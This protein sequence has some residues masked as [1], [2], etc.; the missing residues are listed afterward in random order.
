MKA[1]HVRRLLLH[2]SGRK[3]NCPC[4]QLHWYFFSMLSHLLYKG[5]ITNNTWPRCSGYSVVNQHKLFICYTNKRDCT[6]FCGIVHWYCW[7]FGFVLDAWLASCFVLA[8][9]KRLRTT[10]Q[11]RKQTNWLSIGLSLKCRSSSN[12]QLA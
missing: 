9:A 7:R 5:S 12:S 8:V 4:Q 11:Q 6:H 2:H 1:L 10:I 3:A